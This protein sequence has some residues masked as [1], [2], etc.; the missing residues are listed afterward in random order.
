MS[1]APFTCSQNFSGGAGLNS[2]VHTAMVGKRGLGFHNSGVC[3]VGSTKCSR[4]FSRGHGDICRTC[5][6]SRV[7]CVGSRKCSQTKQRGI[8]HHRPAFRT[9]GRHFAPPTAI[10]HHR[11]SFRTTNNHFAPQEWLTSHRI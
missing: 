6:W 8:S 1:E 5:A 10:S 4:I 7:C 3:Y 9:T 11:R 2:C